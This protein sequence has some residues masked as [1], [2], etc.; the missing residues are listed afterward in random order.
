M[1][2]KRPSG[3]RAW[4]GLR[5]VTD[6]IR[7]GATGPR[8]PTRAAS[9]MAAPVP[10]RPDATARRP[11]HPG[12]PRRRRAGLSPPADS[13][14]GPS[15]GSR[16]GS[17][18]RHPSPTGS[19]TPTCEGGSSFSGRT[20]EPKSHPWGDRRAPEYARVATLDL[21]DYDGG[22]TTHHRRSRRES[23]N[24]SRMRTAERVRGL[25][26]TT[27]PSSRSSWCTSV[28]SALM[29]WAGR[30]AASTSLT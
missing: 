19:C 13:L 30:S 15:A 14:W 12:H 18:S 2:P 24:P 9:R 17:Q 5:V 25:R 22:D 11:F 21:S 3:P 28:S 27:R 1:S 4:F 16:P 26:F 6:P 20:V 8:R 29:K 23:Q 7:G 10:A